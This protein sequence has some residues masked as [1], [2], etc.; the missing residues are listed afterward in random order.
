[1]KWRLFWR[2]AMRSLVRGGQR[3][4]F[5]VFCVA[6][7]VLVIVALQLVGNMVNA[8]LSAN[9]RALNG[10]DVAVHSDTG[11][12]ESQLAYFTQLQAQG[13]IAVYSPATIDDATTTTAA[14]LQRVT[15]FAVDPTTFPL[16]GSLT[17]L[18]PSGGQFAA[19]LQAGDAVVT[20]T[21][22]Q[23]LELHLGQT[24]TLTTGSGRSGSVTITGEIPTAGVITGRADLLM[25]G[26][27]YAG[28]ANLTGSPIG[29]GWVFADVPN[30]DDARAAAVASQIARQLP[31]VTVT[32]ARQTEQ[33]AQRE[34]DNIRT[35]LRVV[36]LLALLI[37]GAGIA[38]TLQVLLRRR[39]VEIAMLKTQ[40][41]R[42]RD[43]LGMFGLE[44]AL[45]GVLGGVLGA[46]AGIG[47]SFAVRA[48]VE[49]AFVLTLPAIIDPGI[50][51]SG[52][53]IGLATTLIFGLLPIVRTS[54]VRP[55]VALREQGAGL[56]SAPGRSLSLLFLLGMLFFALALSILGSFRVTVAV[57]GAS[58]VAL[59]L[60]AGVF[61][62]VASVISVWPVPSP[63][64]VGSLL[65]LVPPLLM[66]LVLLRVAAGFGALLLLAVAG[67]VLVALLPRSARAAVQ[68]ALRNIGRARV[69]SAVTLLALFVGVFAIGLGLLLGQDLKDFIA[70]RNAAVNQDDAY[71]LIAS[72]S[73][74]AVAAQVAQLPN[75]THE[76]TSLAVPDRITAVNGVA[77]ASST[78]G[79]AA[80]TLSAVDGFDLADGQLPPALLEQG[81]QDSQPGRLLTPQDAGTLNALFPV[82]ILRR[83]RRSSWATR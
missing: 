74:P 37:G 73:A 58:G 31:L 9:I 69:R 71:V 59:A 22:M 66:G 10:G 42:Q 24:L 15:F 62:V 4:L 27:T 52:V 68:L 3:T 47:L 81:V 70:S 63:R 23:R 7:G 57:V 17:P 53:G 33:Q 21:A 40:G 46:L 49:R 39:L 8:A 16:A 55:L 60:L 50:V 64:H 38:N 11:I 77:A 29:Y 30:H 65:A 67:G 19:L 35:L 26:A 56:A 34:I 44:A 1:M 6:V 75:V 18:A 51:A 76:Q 79:T 61:T 36:G 54:E 13:T 48:L 5:A 78:P 14:G 43:L 80:A 20:D 32:T 2:Y 72:A 83:P 25:S 82:A 12:P 28:L 41:Y 45:L